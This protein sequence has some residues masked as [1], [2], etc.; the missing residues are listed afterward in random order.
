MTLTKE[1]ERLLDSA[2]EQTNI[3]RKCNI[4]L[5]ILEMHKDN[6]QAK[7]HIK[8]EI[9][10]HFQDID[11]FLNIYDNEEVDSFYYYYMGKKYGQD[12]CDVDTD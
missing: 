6:I 3:K 5:H 7:I 9:S 2:Y 8:E 12:N 10:K 1:T 4:F 11:K